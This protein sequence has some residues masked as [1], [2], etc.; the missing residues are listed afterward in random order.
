MYDLPRL[1][2]NEK[3]PIIL[4]GKSER[5]RDYY[6]L[7]KLLNE[8]SMISEPRSVQRRSIC[9]HTLLGTSVTTRP[10]DAAP[11]PVTGLAAGAV[12]A[13]VSETRPFHW[14]FFQ[15]GWKSLVPRLFQVDVAVAEDVV[16]THWVCMLFLEPI[17][18][19][20]FS[21]GCGVCGKCLKYT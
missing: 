3:A 16:K 7:S 21:G 9:I 20:F 15:W 13:A 12:G 5:F 1:V 11:A 17:I 19:S 10:Q 4:E 8:W 18:V 2:T 14:P 6:S